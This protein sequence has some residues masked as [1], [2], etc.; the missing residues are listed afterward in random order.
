[1]TKQ[2]KQSTFMNGTLVGSVAIAVIVFLVIGAL[3]LVGGP[4][5]K[6][7]NRVSETENRIEQNCA[8]IE[9]IK[10]QNKRVEDNIRIIQTD[11]KEILRQVK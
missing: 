9:N 5:I 1:M 2:E 4:Y 7:P 6:L 11:I 10:K 3:K 8:E